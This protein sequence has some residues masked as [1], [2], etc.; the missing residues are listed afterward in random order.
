MIGA[1][2]ISPFDIDGAVAE[3]PSAASNSW[4]FA[5]YFCAPTSS[6]ATTGTIPTTSRSGRRSKISAC[7]WV[8]TRQTTRR[9]AKSA[10][11]FGYDFML[12]HTFAHPVEQMLAVGS[13]LRRRHLGSPPEIASRFS[14][15]QLRLA[16]VSPLALGRA[17][18]A[19]RRPV[20]A[21]VQQPAEL[22]FQ[23]P[24]LCVGR[25]RRRAGEIRHRL[26][27]QRTAGLLHRLSPCRHQISQSRRAF[28]RT[29][30]RPMKTSARFSGT[31]A[32]PITA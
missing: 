5:R 30:H 21:G 29:A 9:R 8:F 7:R 23:T 1:G 3:T 26:S 11:N 12:R 14:R 4:A 2:M 18:G 13:V 32:R 31:T 19:V 22:L 15:R 17:L 6:T 10:S 27:R 20:G 28:F 24:M 25:M 16:A